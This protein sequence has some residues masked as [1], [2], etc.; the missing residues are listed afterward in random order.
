MSCTLGL[1]P[2]PLP[3]CH[4]ATLPPCHPV[5]LPLCHPAICARTLCCR[6][7]EV[8]EAALG[9]GWVPSHT[10]LTVTM[11]IGGLYGDVRSLYGRVHMTLAQLR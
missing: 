11:M 1:P 4:P 7:D 9:C 10:D 5:P 2:L 8:L 6:L 3:R